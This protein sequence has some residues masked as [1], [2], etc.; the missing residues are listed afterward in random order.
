M[1]AQHTKKTI[2]WAGCLFITLCIVCRPCSLPA[3]EKIAT[4]EPWSYSIENGIEKTKRTYLLVSSP[5]EPQ[6]KRITVV[7]DCQKPVNTE[8]TY[9]TCTHTIRVK[10]SGATFTARTGEDVVMVQTDWTAPLILG[11]VDYG[12]CAGPLV[13]TF[14]REDGKRLGSLKKPPAA[15]QSLYGNAVTRKWDLGNST[16]RHENRPLFVI[17]D[18]LK[19]NAF[20][21]LAKGNGND[22]VRLPITYTNTA[23]KK[24]TDWFLSEF[25]KYGDRDDMTLALEGLFC[26]DSTPEDYVKVLFSCHEGKNAIDCTMR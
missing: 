5:Q 16:G 6:E 8:G 25:V 7:S 24:C 22:L 11:T 26:N 15:L 1:N 12:C 19:D 2:L 17:Q 13:I 9:G 4:A 18:D 10:P 23:E 21:A 3:A 14:Y 20:F